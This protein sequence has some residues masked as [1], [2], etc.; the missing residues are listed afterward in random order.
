M[1]L[2]GGAIYDAILYMLCII[3]PILVFALEARKI[4]VSET[5]RLTMAQTHL[6]FGNHKKAKRILIDLTQKYS[7]SFLGHKMLAHLY[8]QEGGQ[9]KAIDEYVKV[10]EIK[11]KDYDSYYKISLLLNNLGKKE[12]AIE[13]LEKLLKNKP[14]YYEASKLLRRN[15]FKHRRIQ[16]CNRYLH[17]CRKI[18]LR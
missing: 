14:Q 9:R 12:E 1:I 10:L 6:W 8:E 11:K 2:S 16:K 13:M 17:K 7:N 4:N 18:L 15:I 3:I 5:L